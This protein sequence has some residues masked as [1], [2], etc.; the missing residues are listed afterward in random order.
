MQH[1]SLTNSLIMYT[2]SM[3]IGSF[4]L[5]YYAFHKSYYSIT[6]YLQ[7]WVHVLCVAVLDILLKMIFYFLCKSFFNSFLLS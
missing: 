1:C 6:K 7:F 3:V 2:V 5:E 4:E